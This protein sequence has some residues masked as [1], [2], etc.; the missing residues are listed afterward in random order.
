MGIHPRE[1]TASTTP[2]GGQTQAAAVTA[3]EAGSRSRTFES[4]GLLSCQ[5]AAPSQ[6]LEAPACGSEAL[7]CDA[8][9][10][11]RVDQ[12]REACSYVL[13]ENWIEIF[14]DGGCAVG[15]TEGRVDPNLTTA[16]KRCLSEAIARLRAG[17]PRALCIR[18]E[19]STL[20]AL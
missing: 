18:L 20:A 11:Q 10:A 9:L 2:D 3:P 1:S 5:T 16:A 6:L 19:R 15:T 17:C 13:D 14:F 7:G 4:L 8:S 12:L